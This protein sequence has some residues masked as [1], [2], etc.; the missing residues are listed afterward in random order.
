MTDATQALLP[1][2]PEQA[3]SFLETACRNWS[4]IPGLSK[5][6]VEDVRAALADFLQKNSEAAA[7][8]GLRTS[9]EHLLEVGEFCRTDDTESALRSVRAALSRQAH[10]LPG[11]VGTD[12]ERLARAMNP[13]LWADDEETAHMAASPLQVCSAR[14]RGVEAA[15]LVLVELAALT[16]SALSGGEGK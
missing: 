8:G 1:V 2:T 9:V 7:S 12:P 11:D 10:S 13:P 16:P 5:A 4:R 3:T 15:K 14:A 6:D